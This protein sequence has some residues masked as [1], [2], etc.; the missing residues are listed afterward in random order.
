MPTDEA[1]RISGSDAPAAVAGV[2]P[3]STNP[4]AVAPARKDGRPIR[5]G[6]PPAGPVGGPGGAKISGVSSAG[7]RGPGTSR[8]I[9]DEEGWSTV[10]LTGSPS[11]PPAVVTGGTCDIAGR[12]AVVGPGPTGWRGQV[13]TLRP[14]APRPAAKRR[15]SRR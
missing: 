5:P 14:P 15:G 4:S 7:A 9:P 10:W 13:C 2:N 3:T 8:S 6:S 12:S 11:R 1:V